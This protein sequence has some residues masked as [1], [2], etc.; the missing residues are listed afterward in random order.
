LRGS[1]SSGPKFFHFVILYIYVETSA[2]L[3]SD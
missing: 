1:P 3:F 2:L